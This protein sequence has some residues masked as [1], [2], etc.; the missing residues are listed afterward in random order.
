MKLL[1][2]LKEYEHSFTAW[3]AKEYQAFRNEEPSLVALADRVFPYA[4]SAIQIGLSFES[5]A[6]AT[7]AGPILDKIHSTFDTASG[8]IY[9]F[10]A[11]PTV[12]SLIATAQND[13]STFESVSGIKSTQ[14][15]DAVQKALTSI[16]ALASAVTAMIAAAAPPA[17]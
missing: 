15:K 10:G 17:A 4:K 7:A 2:T 9:D 11:S 8:L 5:P 3:V 13:L 1:D 14:A 12:S 16:Q 6:I